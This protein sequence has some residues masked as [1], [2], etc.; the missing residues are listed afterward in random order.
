[1]DEIIIEHANQG[2]LK[3]VSLRLPKNKLIAVTGVSGSG[4]STSMFYSTSVNDN[5]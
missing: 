4:K 3:D 5:I 2:N 1:M